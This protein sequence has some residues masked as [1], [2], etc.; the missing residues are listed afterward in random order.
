MVRVPATEMVGVT[1]TSDEAHR[2]LAALGDGKLGDP[3]LPENQALHRKLQVMLQIA[4]ATERRKA[5]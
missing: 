3:S 5:R 4:T 2:L 1:L